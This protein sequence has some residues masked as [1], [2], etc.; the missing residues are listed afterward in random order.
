MKNTRCICL[1]IFLFSLAQARA[2]KSPAIGYTDLGSS[3]EFV[4][5]NQPQ[6]V[7]GG[8]TIN[9]E[10]R[11][12]EIKSVSLAG[13]FNGWKPNQPGFILKQEGQ[14]YKLVLPKNIGKPGE[15]HQFKFVLNNKYWVEPPA[16][17]SNKF[18]GADGNVNLTIRL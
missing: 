5:G 1:V 15:I 16:N 4:F 11:R 13:D 18:K 9:F 2:Q 17:A 14:L 6:I 10:D 7:I 3:I 8:L 12:K